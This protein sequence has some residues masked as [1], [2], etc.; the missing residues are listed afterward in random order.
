MINTGVIELEP[1]A[2]SNTNSKVAVQKRRTALKEIS[3]MKKPYLPVPVRPLKEIAVLSQFQVK[4]VM[5]TNL[6]TVSPYFSITQ[7]L[8]FMAKH[9]HTG[10]PVVDENG[11]FL[12]IVALDDLTKVDKKKRGEVLIQDV[13]QKNSNVIFP[14]E[15]ALTAFNKMRI[16]KTDR[17]AVV[18]SSNTKK[19]VGLLTR[20]DLG[21]ILSDTLNV[22]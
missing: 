4:D 5:S 1:D 10:Y 20:T 18:D 2:F 7:L 9:H 15:L 3:D 21:H 11:D 22:P 8:D 6:N 19:I 13:M 12:G 17:I 16:N 14:E